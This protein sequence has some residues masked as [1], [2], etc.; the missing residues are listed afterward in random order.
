MDFRIKV[1]PDLHTSDHYPILLEL[2]DSD[3]EKK[4]PHF[5]YKKA[6]WQSLRS[7][8]R[9]T[10]TPEHLSDPSYE[11]QDIMEVITTKLTQIANNNIPKTS[12]VKTKPSKPWIDEECKVLI[13]ERKKAQRFNERHP[14]VPNSIR[15]KF[16]QAQSRKIFRRKKRQT[17]RNY[18]LSYTE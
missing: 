12:N 7:E 17:W 16:L 1:L 13:R 18:T 8:C 14:S 10:I 2:G 4:V 15:S 9:N 5:N 6:D 3:A 11:G